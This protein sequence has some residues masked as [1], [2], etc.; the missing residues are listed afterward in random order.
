MITVSFIKCSYC[1]EFNSQLSTAYNCFIKR[2][3]PLRDNSQGVSVSVVL[4]A[5]RFIIL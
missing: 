4:L 5:E 3:L 1:E 2:L